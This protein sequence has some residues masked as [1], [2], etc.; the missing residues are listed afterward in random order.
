MGE[1]DGE[2]L[3]FK[4]L[5]AGAGKFCK[6]SPFIFLFFYYIVVFSNLVFSFF[7]D[8]VLGKCGRKFLF[9]L[10]Y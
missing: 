7:V 8:I 4:F 5:D 10:T 1:R 6:V 3:F 9:V 2:R